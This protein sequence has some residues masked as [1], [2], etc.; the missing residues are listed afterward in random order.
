MCIKKWRVKSLFIGKRGKNVGEI[1]KQW[2]IVFENMRL[3]KIS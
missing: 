1:G 3:Y 2:K